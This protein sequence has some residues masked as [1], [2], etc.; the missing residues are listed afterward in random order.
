VND[1]N[2]VALW[3]NT[4]LGY[5]YALMEPEERIAIQWALVCESWREVGPEK[6]PVPFCGPVSTITVIPVWWHDR[7]RTAGKQVW[8]QLIAKQ[9]AHLRDEEDEEDEEE[10]TPP[11]KQRATTQEGKGKQELPVKRRRGQPSP[12]GTGAP[13]R[14]NPPRQADKTGIQP[15]ASTSKSTAPPTKRADELPSTNAGL[16]SSGTDAPSGNKDEAPPRLSGDDAQAS[17]APPP[18]R[19]R[20]MTASELAGESAAP[21]TTISPGKQASKD[22]LQREAEPSYAT[23]PSTQKAN[24]LSP[25]DIG[26]GVTGLVLAKTSSSPIGQGKQVMTEARS[27]Q[28]R[29]DVIAEFT[30]LS[31]VD[32]G[33]EPGVPARSVCQG[34]IAW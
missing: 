30:R 31:L 6:L 4:R 1:R 2:Q 17:G 24:T 22:R 18:K 15:R 26:G 9:T 33:G 34:A 7:G 8:Q 23:G 29:A 20:V 11:S 3:I 21:A 12:R 19:S 5:S 32:A 25:L 27:S 28:S 10:A 13:E 16:G 14:S